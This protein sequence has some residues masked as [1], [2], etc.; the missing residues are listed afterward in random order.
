MTNDDRQLAFINFSF[1]HFSSYCW[2]VNIWSHV[3]PSCTEHC[4]VLSDDSLSYRLKT[5]SA[6][7][8]KQPQFQVK[9]SLS[10]RIKTVSAV[11]SKRPQLQDQ[12][13]LSCRFKTASAV[14]SKQPQLQVK[15]SL[16]Y[17]IKTASAVGS[18]QPQLQVKNRLSCSF[19]TATKYIF[20]SSI[21]M[22]VMGRLLHKT[23][24]N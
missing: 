15:K 17:R 18:K 5:A 16:S 19:K 22:P 21:T 24:E 4:L 23:D 13:S 2:K 8:S 11:G 1:Q 6:V 10:Y 14:G 9:N 20:K 7:G 12:N 3:D